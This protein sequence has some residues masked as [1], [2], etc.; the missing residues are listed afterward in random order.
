[1]QL[2]QQSVYIKTIFEKANYFRK[3][4]CQGKMVITDLFTFRCSFS[5]LLGRAFKK[6][7]V[8]R[9]Y[10]CRSNQHTLVY[11]PP[12]IRQENVFAHVTRSHICIMKQK[13]GFA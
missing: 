8:E 2:A 4:G 7:K 10:K 6:I 12:Q 5:L 13:E 11:L 1:M 3:S 9:F